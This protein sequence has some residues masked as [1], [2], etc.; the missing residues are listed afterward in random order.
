MN[1]ALLAAKN[2]GR[3][4]RRT[5]L[6]MAAVALGVTCV[7]LLLGMVNAIQV[8]NRALFVEGG[9]GAL[10]VHRAGW[11]ASADASPLRLDFEDSPALRERVLAVPGVK[12]LAPR[13]A[14]GA[15]VAATPDSEAAWF[16]ATAVDPQAE[17]QVSP[18]RVQWA[19]GWP[20]SK[21]ERRLV[22][23]RVFAQALKL[24]PPGAGA[25]VPPEASW[26]ALLVTDRDDA[27]NG[28]PVLLGGLMGSGLPGDRR[29]GWVP[30]GVA[31]R[32][33]R[34][35]G[36]VTEYGVALEDLR[37]LR[38]ARAALAAALGPDFEVHA[39]DERMPM[40]RDVERGQDVFG[41]VLGGV[42]LVVALLSVANL[43]LMNVLDRRVE[44]GT[45][46][47][48]GMRRRR[49]VGLFVLE[50]LWLAGVGA[51]AGAALG[52]GVLRALS[53][54]GVALAAPGAEVAQRMFP[55]VHA[56][57]LALVCG[58]TLAGA[59]LAARWAAARVARLDPSDALRD[60]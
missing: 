54:H 26:P 52:L 53:A 18:L 33:L 10:Q 38:R 29:Q 17:G 11:V 34:M 51:A 24:A 1:L 40:L 19:E 55:A 41:A 50:G 8:A 25:A 16:S 12:A 43:L 58:L 4:P 20:A 31:Q 6:G 60:G 9:L 49:V 15:A 7:L 30:L 44:V 39:W 22:L 47:A 13:I 23:D 42:V 46:L 48:L 37:D 35:E 27:L 21:D 3:R 36:R 57:Q 32:V 59:A 14:F 28:E 5:V 56:W 45:V 2:L